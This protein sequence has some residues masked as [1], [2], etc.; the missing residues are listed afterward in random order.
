MVNVPMSRDEIACVLGERQESESTA[1][2]SFCSP[3]LILI[4]VDTCA[5]VIMRPETLSPRIAREGANS[6]LFSQ[7]Y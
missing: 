6:K 4:P 2:A 3:L 5:T 1:N 7:D